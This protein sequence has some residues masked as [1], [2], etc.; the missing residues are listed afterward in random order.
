MHRL[1][2]NPRQFSQ[3]AVLRFHWLDLDAFPA[4]N[5][6]HISLCCKEGDTTAIVLNR[7]FK[8]ELLNE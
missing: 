5:R 3:Q 7:T 4:R 8:D 1:V 2:S 6:M